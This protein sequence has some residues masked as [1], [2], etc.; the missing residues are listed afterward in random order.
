MHGV[1]SSRRR[2]C[3]CGSQKWRSGPNFLL[4]KLDNFYQNLIQGEMDGAV[5]S[6]TSPT[7]SSMFYYCSVLHTVLFL[8]TCYK[9][10]CSLHI[11]VVVDLKI[12]NLNRAQSKSRI[13]LHTSQVTLQ[14]YFILVSEHELTSSVST[15]SLDRML[16]QCR[17]TP[18]IKV[19]IP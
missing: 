11:H 7:W 14:P 15:P 13:N 8:S 2:W 10:R 1:S 9:Q 6:S 5:F 12:L 19:I 4:Q 3:K 18:S 16:V 17:V